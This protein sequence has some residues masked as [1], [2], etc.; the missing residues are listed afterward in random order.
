MEESVFQH[1]QKKKKIKSTICFYIKDTSKF[2]FRKSNPLRIE[3]N[4]IKKLDLESRDYPKINLKYHSSHPEIIK[5]NNE[6]IIR[7]MRP[8]KSIISVSGLD[9]KSIKLEVIAI[10]NNGLINNFTLSKNNAGFYQTL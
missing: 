6:G 4:H 2:F 3:T 9:S 7:A 10:S 8:G 5:I 1:I